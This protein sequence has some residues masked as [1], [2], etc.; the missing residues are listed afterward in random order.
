[1]KDFVSTN[2]VWQGYSICL[3]FLSLQSFSIHKSLFLQYLETWKTVTLMGNSIHVRDCYYNCCL[4][5][6][7]RSKSPKISKTLWCSLSNQWHQ[8]SCSVNLLLC[9]L[10]L[11]LV[12]VKIQPGP[13]YSR[14]S[15][16]KSLAPPVLWMPVQASVICGARLWPCPNPEEWGVGCGC[17]WALAPM[18]PGDEGGTSEF[19][20]SLF[21]WN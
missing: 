18:M 8:R 20:R 5:W 2:R 17:V 10:V 13:G 9:W 4:W 19:V 3:P 21:L 7:W 15:V 11:S 14:S 16:H 12:F 6:V 1:M